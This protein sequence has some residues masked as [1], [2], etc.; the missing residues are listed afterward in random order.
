[1]QENPFAIRRLMPPEIQLTTTE[2][3]PAPPGAHAEWFEARDGTRL[4]VARFAGDDTSRGTVV[5]LNG[6]TE[7]IEKYF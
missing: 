7:F 2:A 1:M 5:F 4:R 3:D 6:R